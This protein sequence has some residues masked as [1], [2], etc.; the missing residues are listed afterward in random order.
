VGTL[1]LG[2]G[3]TQLDLGG[4]NTIGKIT[5][6]NPTDITIGNADG[7][8]TTFTGKNN[9]VGNTTIA[10][11][12]QA[13]LNNPDSQFGSTGDVTNN[14]TIRFGNGQGIGTLAVNGN[15]IGNN[16]S[17]YLSSNL[18]GVSSTVDRLAISGNASGNPML[19]LNDTGKKV[20]R[21]PLKWCR[22]AVPEILVLLH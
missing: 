3:T 13:V 2:N 21:F 12:A 6:A 22:S 15:Y 20:G 5:S 8:T 7:G 9:Y 16:A 11:R 19:Y 14:G 17:I 18:I 10:F 1:A 4:N